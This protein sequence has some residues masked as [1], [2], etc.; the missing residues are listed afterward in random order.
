MAASRSGSRL[1]AKSA[2]RSFRLF[3]SAR[4]L[5][6]SIRHLAGRRAR[7]PF[8]SDT[9]LLARPRPRGRR[10]A[11]P[12]GASQVRMEMG[13]ARQLVARLVASTNSH[14]LRSRT[15]LAQRPTACTLGLCRCLVA[16][17]STSSCVTAGMARKRGTGKRLEH[18]RQPA[19]AARPTRL[20]S[21]WDARARLQRQGARQCSTL[22]FLGVRSILASRVSQTV[23]R[24]ALGL[25]PLQ[26]WLVALL[27][28]RQ[29]TTPRRLPTPAGCLLRF[30]Q[31][32]TLEGQPRRLR[33][34]GASLSTSTRPRS[35]L[36]VPS[37][38]S[39]QPQATLPPAGGPGPP[40]R[41]SH[42]T[43]TMA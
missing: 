20:S 41:R 9:R 11:R 35:L 4:Q 1:P 33:R 7:T 36:Q 39:L 29:D 30:L 19:R 10:A 38:M 31:Q 28:P 22:P 43:R 23:V 8:A 6:P 5:R 12:M 34:A 26:G 14:P 18:K 40:P 13:R 27:R 37:V 15:R 21:L 25:S 16:A 24:S 32:C 42:T 2:Q 17:R 3:R